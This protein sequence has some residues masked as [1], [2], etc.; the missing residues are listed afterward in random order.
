MQ[1][2]E[3]SAAPMDRARLLAYTLSNPATGATNYAPLCAVETRDLSC[4]SAQSHAPPNTPAGRSGHGDV[5]GS[6]EIEF[7]REMIRVQ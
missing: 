5:R 4:P 1:W 7:R 6:V 2:G 3:A